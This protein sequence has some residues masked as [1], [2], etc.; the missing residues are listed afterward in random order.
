MEKYS[1]CY[2]ILFHGSNVFLLMNILFLHADVS[3]LLWFVSMR[4][5][6]TFFGRC[7]SDYSVGHAV[8]LWHRV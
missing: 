2:Y 3:Q 4:R 7:M 8:R 6:A 5:V 1:C